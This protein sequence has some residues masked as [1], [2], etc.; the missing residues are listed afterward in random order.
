[1]YAEDRDEEGYGLLEL[2]PE[3]FMHVVSKLG[4]SNVTTGK[5]I[6]FFK[7]IR[8]DKGHPGYGK[9]RQMA[10]KMAKQNK[11]TFVKQGRIYLISLTEISK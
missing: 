6:E 9:I 8:T 4:G 7:N 1:V 5:M 11:V 2:T 3:N 10:K